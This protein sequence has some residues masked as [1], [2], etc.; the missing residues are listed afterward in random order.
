MTRTNVGDVRPRLTPI[1]DE[2]R[3]GGDERSQGGR[4]GRK[5]GE[6]L[7][8]RLEEGSDGHGGSGEAEGGE[9]TAGAAGASGGGGRRGA[10]ARNARGSRSVAARGRGGAGG[11]AVGGDTEGAANGR[12]GGNRRVVGTDLDGEE[13]RANNGA[14]VGLVDV[15]LV[16]EELNVA[17]L[18]LAGVVGGGG[19]VVTLGE[20]EEDVTVG[21]RTVSGRRA[22]VLLDGGAVLVDEGVVGCRRGV[23]V[24]VV[25]QPVEVLVG[26]VKGG[27]D[28]VGVDEESSVLFAESVI[29]NT[30]KQP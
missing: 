23:E 3:V 30:N 22:L 29:L 1:I 11:S 17:N 15:L 10:R 12:G 2:R 9:D 28:N 6:C 5:G 25:D 26:A 19:E 18:V 4:I 27:A 16:V 13:G 21:A 20:D 8:Y 24:D 14:K 7:N